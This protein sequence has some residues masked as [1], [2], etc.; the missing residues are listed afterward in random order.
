LFCSYYYKKLFF[1][2]VIYH[3]N[4]TDRTPDHWVIRSEKFYGR[5]ETLALARKDF[6]NAM[7]KD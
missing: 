7:L 4:I 3:S 1:L 2:K 5:G 6:I